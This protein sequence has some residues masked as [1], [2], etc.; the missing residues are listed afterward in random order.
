MWYTVSLPVYVR[1]FIDDLILSRNQ[2]VSP[3]KKWVFLEEFYNNNQIRF[4]L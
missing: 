4:S 1:V 3:E 2:D